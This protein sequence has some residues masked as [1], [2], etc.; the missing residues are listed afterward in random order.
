MPLSAEN[1]RSSR[2]RILITFLLMIVFS[3]L[4]AWFAYQQFYSNK[5]EQ[6][7]HI[8]DQELLTSATLI[9]RELGNLSDLLTLLASSKLL[10]HDALT[11]SSNPTLSSE[12]SKQLTDY[13][14]QFGHASTKIA[15]IRW[16]DSSGQEL[17]RI[18][19]IAGNA[20]ITEAKLLQNKAN[21]YYVN[22][23]LK[24]T[25]PH[26]YL[27]PIDLNVENGQVVRPF[28][29]TIRGTIQTTD[30]E[31]K[32]RGLLVVNYRLDNLLDAI[33]QLSIPEAQLSIVNDQ[34]FWLL[35]QQPQKQWGFMLEQPQ[36]NLQN[37]SPD[38]WTYISQ[39]PNSGEVIIDKQLNSFIRMDIFNAPDSEA[40]ASHLILLTTSDKEFLLS[41][42]KYALY[43]AL[44]VFVVLATIGLLVNWQEY[45][46]QAT[47]ISLSLALQ[48]ERQELHQ[49]NQTLVE[50]IARQQLL[51]DELVEANKLSALGLTVA[52]VAHELNT[53]LGG[54]IMSVSNAHNANKG[55]EK[56]M[57]EGISKT[58]F[59]QGVES[60]N[61]SLD[62]AKINL[63]KAV[64]LIKH[65][66]R[67][68]IDRVNEDYIQCSIDDI[69]GDLVVSLHHRLKHEKIE[70]ITD[71]APNLTLLSRPGIIS[72]VIE[73]LVN[74][75]LSHAFSQGQVG[76]IVIKANKY[77]ENQ[78]CLTV[79]DNGAGIP[80]EM[81]AHLFEPFVTSG[82]GKGNIGL[83]L[84]MVNQWVIKLLNG[85]LS[86]VSEKNSEHD[87]VTQF[88]VV[89]PIDCS[90]DKQD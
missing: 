18:D 75:S 10:S 41:A 22:Q 20:I 26:T 48:K 7:R 43:L 84:Y 3:S 47:L 80:S 38:L 74:N 83:G 28:E 27:S 44:G 45:R 32:L 50:N 29:P 13:F 73:N 40:T 88:T 64:N 33:N 36:V 23:G 77:S 85:H 49:L 68:A 11:S 46:Y 63:N 60:I 61:S 72:Q 35:N 19:F 87:F 70:L 30:A 37:E 42:N 59:S 5:I 53:P 90:Q 31:H 67:L 24:V 89:I 79:S 9:S 1:I 34:G 82:R 57:L 56:A 21:R 55:L 69:V 16:L 52:G 17:I 4:V 54:A 14:I 86:F 25:P 71:I 15:Q 78:I 12:T 39:H 2:S 65:F 58:Q 8:H 81:Q 51:Q 6:L 66:K 76:D 62:L